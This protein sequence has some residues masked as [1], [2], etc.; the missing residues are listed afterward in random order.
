MIKHTWKINKDK[1]ILNYY[2]C[3]KIR[4]KFQIMDQSIIEFI[5]KQKTASV[6]CVDRG[7]PYC[8]SCYYSFNA[9]EG[10][11]YFKSSTDTHHMNL[12]M[13]DPLV[14]GTIL[15]DKLQQLAIRGI[16]FQG[17]MLPAHDLRTKDAYKNYHKAFPFAL[18]ISGDVWAIQIDQ[19]KMVDNT[20]GFKHKTSWFR[21]ETLV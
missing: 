17:V 4:H 14:A 21:T 10:L 12:L 15:P 1:F 19:I 8:F 16:Q 6:C 20:K 9:D 3:K 13:K 18:M 5:T 7:R 2:I 11:L